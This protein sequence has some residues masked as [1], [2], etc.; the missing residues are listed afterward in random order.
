[1]PFGTHHAT[2]PPMSRP[3]LVTRLAVGVGSVVAW[4]AF[5]A[6]VAAHGP[7]PDEPPSA[8]TLL[9]GWTFPPLPS[10]AI[11][12]ALA[13]WTWAV[14]RVN[15]AHPDNHVPRMRTWAFLAGMLALAFALLSGIER[16][17]TT[18]FSVHM[19][20]HLLLTMVAAPLI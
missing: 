9:L 1:M 13:W 16:Y 12:A 8:A 3:A 15:A 5:A 6:P 2:M 7:V 4:V 18:L 14:R 20:Q 19:V 11:L 10:L 17:D